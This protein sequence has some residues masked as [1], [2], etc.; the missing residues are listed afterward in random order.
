MAKKS[1]SRFL[2]SKVFNQKKNSTVT[3]EFVGTAVRNKMARNRDVT[4]QSELT[5]K[6]MKIAPKK[7]G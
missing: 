4:G 6:Q 5:S 2:E 1:K 3:G 7:L